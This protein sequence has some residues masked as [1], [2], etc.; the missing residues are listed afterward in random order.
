MLSDLICLFNKHAVQTYFEPISC[1]NGLELI[2]R[3]Y[4]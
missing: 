3:Y 1:N 4:S 2:D